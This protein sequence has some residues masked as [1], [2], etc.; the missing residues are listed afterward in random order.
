[1]SEWL[2]RIFW[3]VC[4]L[5]PDLPDLFLSFFPGVLKLH[6]LSCTSR[7]DHLRRQF[8]SKT[9][10]R[11]SSQQHIV[12]QYYGNSADGS[13]T[14]QLAIVNIIRVQDKSSHNNLAF[15]DAVI[16][17]PSQYLAQFCHSISRTHPLLYQFRS[18][19]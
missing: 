5:Q 3:L 4:E 11:S 19:G 15:T 18:I 2:Y 16:Y 12:C 7:V 1:M 14:P 6:S 13:L 17:L 8:R 10:L 9:S